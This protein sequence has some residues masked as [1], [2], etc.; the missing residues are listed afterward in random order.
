M[1]IGAFLLFRRSE[2]NP[3]AAGRFGEVEA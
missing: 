1:L 2:E 3:G